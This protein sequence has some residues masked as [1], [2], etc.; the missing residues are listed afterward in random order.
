MAFNLGDIFVTLKAKTDGLKSGIKDVSDFTN[1]IDDG[2]NKSTFA[3][4]KAV[5]AGQLLA[6]GIKMVAQKALE[7]G[8]AAIESASD[9]E[10]SRVAFEV[11]LGSADKARKMMEDIAEFAK[12][13]PFELPEV[14]KGSKQ[15]LAF[16]FAQEQIIPT[17]RK[18][19]D[20][21]AGVG[22]PIGQI[23]YVFGQVRVAGKLMGGDLMQFTNAG[24]PMIEGLSKV[25]GVTQGEVKKMVELGKV[26]FPEVEA[27]INNLTKE[28]SQ[29]GGMMEKQSKT[30]GGVVSNI[31]DGFGQMLRAAVGVSNAGD[32]VEGGLFDRIKKGAEKVMPIL[33]DLSEKVGPAMGKLMDAFDKGMLAIQV[34]FQAFKDPDITSK[35][36]IGQVE[37]VAGVIRSFWDFLVKMFGPSLKAL[38]ETVMDRLWPALK[39]IWE[40]IVRLEPVWKALAITIGAIVVAAIWLIINALNVVISVLSWVTNLIVALWN[41][42][43]TTFNAIVGAIQ[44]FWQTAQ[45]VFNAFST[46]VTTVF[47]FIYESVIKPIFDLIIGILNVFLAIYTYIFQV[48][49][50]VAIVVWQ[51]IYNFIKPILDA[52]GSAASWLGGVITGVWNW[53]LSVA[54]TAWN[55]IVAGFRWAWDRVVGIWHAAAGFFGDIWKKIT[56]TASGIG[57]A[58]A[59]AVSS[60]F[61]SVKNIAKGAVNWMIDKIN[62]VIGG[63]NKSAGKLPGVPDIPKID[64]LFK[65]VRN[66]LG[67]AAIV[68][69][70]GPEIVQMPRGSNV[71]SANETRQMLNKSKPG[72]GV[73]VMI[74]MS[75]ATITSPHVAD[76]YGEKIGDAFIRRLMQNVRI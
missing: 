36:F 48:I 6:D 19:G 5:A 22:V 34:F 75:G 71:F 35:G 66:W 54:S 30:F 16:G 20:I 31:K 67:G 76:Q 18:L 58:V 72:G 1:H 50:G 24:V 21:A 4:T 59:N 28:G 74:D 73:T 44:W 3:M 62:G 38:G 49:R 65:G 56:D 9:F 7:M 10:Q 39:N 41:A 42:A 51:E 70:Q 33:M 17:M 53:I 37:K 12:A 11:M 32:I 69:D 61:E 45:D 57:S 52:L 13:T 68:G 63:V 27:V 26:G 47:T 2:A 25:L 15:L 14:V 64:R 8:K 55:G 43:I 40:L 23:A 29:F 46:L 60:A